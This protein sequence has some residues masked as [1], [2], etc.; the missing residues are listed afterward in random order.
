MHTGFVF[1]VR[2]GV[3]K[4]GLKALL[5]KE[6]IGYKYLLKNFEIDLKWNT[7]IFNYIRIEYDKRLC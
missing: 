5:E 1:F 2:V 7:V 4:D 6:N 3:N